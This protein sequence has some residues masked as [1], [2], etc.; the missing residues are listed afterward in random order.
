MIGKLENGSHTFSAAHTWYRKAVY[1]IDNVGSSVSADYLTAFVNDELNVRVVSCFEVQPRRRRSNSEMNSK[2]FRL[3]INRDDSQ[4][5]L[6]PE[7]WP[8]Y[9]GISTWQ[10]KS[11]DAETRAKKPHLDGPD[12]YVRT[13]SSSAVGPS[14]AAH[15]GL[16]TEDMETT[17]LADTPE[18]GTPDDGNQ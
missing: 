4:L 18:Y 2:A 9:V 3:C 11:G 16:S 10:F 15:H 12:D 6:I 13:T 1:Y 7:K 5:L 14:A 17:I 8:A